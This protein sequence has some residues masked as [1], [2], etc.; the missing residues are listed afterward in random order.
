MFA[1]HGE[2][3]LH[4]R[5][6]ENEAIVSEGKVRIY[7]VKE[8]YFLCICTKA[9]CAESLQSCLAL[10]KPM[11]SSPPGSSVHGILQSRI[12]EW[13]SM[14][15]SRGSS[16]PGIESMSPQSP[17]LAGRF[18]TTSAT[19]EAWW[20]FASYLF[21]YTLI[22]D[23]N[24]NNQINGEVHWANCGSRRNHG[25]SMPLWTQP[26]PSTLNNMFIDY[27]GASQVAQW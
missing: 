1:S 15:S 2:T 8:L 27:F 21:I 13:V 22:K 12:L 25:A 5:L 6:R 16:P 10:C 3:I 9:T 4:K 20:L 24:P 7:P 23:T 18:F 17:A 11:D 26:S 14:P 19:W